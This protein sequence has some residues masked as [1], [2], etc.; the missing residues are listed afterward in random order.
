M[1]LEDKTNRRWG[2]VQA[3]LNEGLC[4]THLRGWTLKATMHTSMSNAAAL[5]WLFVGNDVRI[6]SLAFCWQIATTGSL[7]A[8]STQT[9]RILL[10]YA[11]SM[12]E[13][14]FYHLPSAFFGAVRFGQGKGWLRLC[15][16]FF[17]FAYLQSSASITPSL[18]NKAPHHRPYCCFNHAIAICNYH[19]VS[20]RKLQRL[21]GIKGLWVK[22][23]NRLHP[24]HMWLF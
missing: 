23:I 10:I 4:S 2:F 15:R 5:L 24:S 9:A 17:K 11:N 16:F 1:W 22:V 18:T 21:M 12:N 3:Q 20:M 13:V 19:T 6:L 7:L 8:I 14:R